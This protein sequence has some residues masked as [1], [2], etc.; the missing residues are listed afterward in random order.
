MGGKKDY[1]LY[2]EIGH[3][4][5][6]LK[7]KTKENFTH[8][9]TVYLRG[10]DGAKIE[11]C[12]S[13]VVFQ[14]HESFQNPSRVIT[15]PP[16]QV[17]ELGYAGFELPI[18]V[19]FRNR[20]KPNHVTYVHNLQL[21]ITAKHVDHHYEK[22]LFLNPHRDF[23]K[24][25]I[26]AGAQLTSTKSNKSEKQRSVSPPI[27][28]RKAESSIIPSK[29]MNKINTSST[30]SHSNGHHK[31]KEPTVPKESKNFMDVFGAPLVYT[32]KQATSNNNSNQTSN[33]T[34]NHKNHDHHHHNHHS[35]HHQQQQHQEKE[36]DRE[37]EKDKSH[38]NSNN[39]GGNHTSSNHHTSSSTQSSSSTP[40][41]SKDAPQPQAPPDNFQILQAKISALT[42][43]DRLQK[44]VDI[45]EESK[46]WFNLTPKKFE[47]DLKRLNKRTLHR[48]E[49]CL[50]SS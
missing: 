3:K 41:P 1:E 16:Y 46:E 45:I 15:E 47:F 10:K 20:E 29:D 37:K 30:Q 17:K 21:L 25:L 48:I 26:R 7:R 39:H 27:K 13:R 24:C 18:E 2:L 6:P 8:K 11:H 23:E 32:K 50:H 5:S 33:N 14:L 44:I 4:S 31:D 22:V 19:Y 40:P 34:N 28:K 38:N 36:K 9:W 35:H 12:I 42:D 49:K 43:C